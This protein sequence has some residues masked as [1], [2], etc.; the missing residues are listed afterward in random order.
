VHLRI[1]IPGADVSHLLTM[2]RAAIPFYEASTPA[3]VR[4]LKNADDPAQFVQVIEYE[5]EPTI[6]AGRQKLA[7]DPMI[8][9][10]LQIWRTMSMGAAEV[11]VYEDVTGG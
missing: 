11:D 5:S 1:R 3:R 10:Y 9:N 2:I 6:E 7:S 8:Q 4:L